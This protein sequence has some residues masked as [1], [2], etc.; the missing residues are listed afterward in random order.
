[1]ETKETKIKIPMK[2][3]TKRK[4]TGIKS[5]IIKSREEEA[6]EEGNITIRKDMITEGIGIM[7]MMI[8]TMMVTKMI[9]M[10]VMIIEIIIEVGIKD[11]EEG[12]IKIITSGNKIPIEDIIKDTR[13]IIPTV[14]RTQMALTMTTTK[15]NRTINEKKEIIETLNETLNEKK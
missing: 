3:I 15:T 7:T 8:T 4:D 13:R 5:K 9:T 6:K 14:D 10:M 1:V 11:K 2:I 12:I